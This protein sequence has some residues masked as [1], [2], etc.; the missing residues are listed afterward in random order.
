MGAVPQH[1]FFLRV[2]DSLQRYDRSWFLPYI[3]I[4]YST[5]PLFL[6]V[7]WKEYT[8][9]IAAVALPALPP[10]APPAVMALGEESLLQYQQQYH[11]VRILTPQHYA[12]HVISFFKEFPGSSWH[13]SDAQLI[14]WVRTCSPLFFLSLYLF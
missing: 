11:R 5:G 2:I 3:T 6:S 1:P 9:D 10:T 7:V 4:M 14:F 12:R 13:G 8:R